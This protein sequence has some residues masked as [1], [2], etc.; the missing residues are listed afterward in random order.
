ML[1]TQVGVYRKSVVV[2]WC[3]TEY[4]TYLHIGAVTSAVYV[5]INC[6]PI[7]YSQDSKLP[8]EFNLTRALRAGEVNVIVLQVL[9]EPGLASVHGR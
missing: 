1:C 8:A 9:C 3:E 4:T 7:G 5:W 2:P 6:E